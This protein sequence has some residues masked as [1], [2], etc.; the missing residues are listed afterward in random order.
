[1]LL[2]GSLL[3][4]GEH[5]IARRKNKRGQRLSL[6]ILRRLGGG[7]RRSFEIRSNL[8]ICRAPVNYGFGCVTQWLECFVY[9]EEVVGSNPTASTSVIFMSRDSQGGQGTCL[10]NRLCRFDSCSRHSIGMESGRARRPQT[11]GKRKHRVPAQIW[12]ERYLTVK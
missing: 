12:G 11:A 9:I 2:C 3:A 5:K 8:N 7:N 10:K 6:K 4:Y 1:M